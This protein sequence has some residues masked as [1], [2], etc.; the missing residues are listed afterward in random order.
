M[1]GIFVCQG[2]RLRHD[3]LILLAHLVRDESFV[4]LRGRHR[5][6]VKLRSQPIACH[7][8][9]YFSTTDRAV[10]GSIFPMTTIVV[11]SGRMTI[12]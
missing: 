9:K 4:R 11:S 5:R 6:G 8:P 3:D 2:Q 12:L 1:I 7:A 10:A